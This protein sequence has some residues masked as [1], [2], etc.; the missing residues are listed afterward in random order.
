MSQSVATIEPRQQQLQTTG[1]TATPSDLLR[2]AVEQGA[3]LD[4]LERLMDLQERWEANQARR[5]FV[6]AMAAFKAEP[7]E[8]LKRKTVSFTTRDGDT[9]SYTHAELSDVCDGVVPAMAKHGL[10]HA[11]NIQQVDGGVRVTCTITHILGHSESVTMFAAPDASGKKN[12]IQQVASTVT[13]LQ[14]YTLLA[15]CGVA[16]KGTDDDGRASE[17]PIVELITEE[18]E[19]KL[20][21]MIDASGANLPRFLQHMQVEK[22]SDIQAAHY[23]IGLK[24]LQKKIDAKAAGK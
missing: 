4:R 18:Q 1:T 10:S 13:Y 8:I 9:T 20:R 12:A 17:A 5:A 24:I 11:W 22:L 19:A 3:D 16:T 21:E 6:E 23:E 14:R 15:A 7:L 2:L